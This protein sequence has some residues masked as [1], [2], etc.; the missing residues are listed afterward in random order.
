MEPFIKIYWIRLKSFIQYV[1]FFFQSDHL[2][3]VS[4]LR[5]E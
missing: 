2:V 3:H 4:I 5:I 1:Y